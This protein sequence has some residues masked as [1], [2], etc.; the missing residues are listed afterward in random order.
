ME[1][2][3]MSLIAE[4]SCHT[5]IPVDAILSTKRAQR[6]V[7]ARQLAMYAARELFSLSFPQIGA[8]FDRD[9]STVIHAHNKVAAQLQLRP[10]LN[11][12]IAKLRAALVS[13]FHRDPRAVGPWQVDTG[14]AA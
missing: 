14:E 3:M 8:A 4:V 5:N 2:T 9:H 10:E 13:D 7:F 12:T 11:Q 6:I 1:R